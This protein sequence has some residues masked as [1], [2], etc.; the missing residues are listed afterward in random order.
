MKPVRRDRERDGR[1]S[2]GR[3]SVR[4]QLDYITLVPACLLLACLSFP[5]LSLNYQL[6]LILLADSLDILD[7]LQTHRYHYLHKLM[8][9]VE[10]RK[11]VFPF[12][13]TADYVY[14]DIS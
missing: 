6:S 7:N 12:V 14:R 11:G 3:R 2:A 4:C 1:I 10:L 8:S 5:L 9:M 13:L